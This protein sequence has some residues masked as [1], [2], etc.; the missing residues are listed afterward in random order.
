MGLVHMDVQKSSKAS[1]EAFAHAP[2]QAETVPGN[3]GRAV[4]VARLLSIM[5]G[6]AEVR[7]QVAEFLAE[8][9]NQG[10]T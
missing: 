9:L 4:M 8:F 5:Q 10:R 7:A 3:V 1:V 6:R 2:V